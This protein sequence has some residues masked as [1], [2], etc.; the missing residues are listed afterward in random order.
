MKR[1]SDDD[2]LTLLRQKLLLEKLSEVEDFTAHSALMDEAHTA[3][4]LARETGFPLLVF[5]C[6]FSERAATAEQALREGLRCYWSNL[7]FI[8]LSAA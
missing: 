1:Q 7:R 8:E 5:P 2:W 3:A 6:L 4:Q